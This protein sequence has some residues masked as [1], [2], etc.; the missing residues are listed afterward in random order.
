MAD[1]PD[2]P[3]PSNE[4][5]AK[6]VATPQFDKHL[7]EFI[8]STKSG[9][10]AAGLCAIIALEHFEAHGNTVLIQRF[11]DAMKAHGNNYVRQR[12]FLAW[13]VAFSPLALVKNKFIKDT[14]E[15]ANPFDIES[16][17]KKHFWDF[18]P[19]APIVDFSMDDIDAALIGLV[20]RYKTS[21]KLRPLDEN[22]VKRLNQIEGFVVGLTG[23]TIDIPEEAND[24][25]EQ[26][27][28]ATGTNG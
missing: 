19:E 27:A 9:M 12:A 22:A 23:H 8:R 18:A 4:P 25:V 1:K 11:S 3:K 17:K 2:A 24:T 6:T 14:G 20:K 15:N 7:A 5:E 21:K 16:A 10:K 13:A 28:A 26:P